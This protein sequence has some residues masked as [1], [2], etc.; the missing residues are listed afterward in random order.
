MLTSTPR[1]V[2]TQKIVC[3]AGVLVPLPPMVLGPVLQKWQRYHNW[4]RINGEPLPDRPDFPTPAD[5]PEVICEVP[6][7]QHYASLLAAG[8]VHLATDKPVTKPKKEKG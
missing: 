5:V 6:K 4:P 3:P 8:I 7:S 1:D 2:G